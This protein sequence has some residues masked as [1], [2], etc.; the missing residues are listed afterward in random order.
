[1]SKNHFGII[2]FHAGCRTLTN[3]YYY[4]RMQRGAINRVRFVAMLGITELHS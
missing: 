3:K 4:R 2:M 1:M